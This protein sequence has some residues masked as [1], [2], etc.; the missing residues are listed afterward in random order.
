MDEF[1][2]ITFGIV[3]DVTGKRSF[4]VTD[5]DSIEDLRL[6][7]ENEYPELK[8]IQYAIAV[9]RKLVTNSTLLDKNATIALLPPFSGG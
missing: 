3:T 5:I 2:I 9:N 8:T 1:N 7:L 6:M 4:T